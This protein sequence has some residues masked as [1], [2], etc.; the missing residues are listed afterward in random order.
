M[1]QK[2]VYTAN[3]LVEGNMVARDQSP[4]YRWPDDGTSTE[5]K[6]AVRGSRYLDSLDG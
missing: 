6:A 4:A 3:A 1:V 5:S 2:K